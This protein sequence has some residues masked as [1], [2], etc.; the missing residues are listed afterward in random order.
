[1]APSIH[2][3]PLKTLGRIFDGTLNDRK[4]R[5]ELEVKVK[6]GLRL[7]DRSLFTG[8]MKLWIL[9][10]VLVPKISWHLM[11]YEIPVSWVER[12]EVKISKH[13]RKWLGVGKMLNRSAL[14]CKEVP[15]PLPVKSLVSIFKT[16]KTNALMQ[17]KQSSDK[18]VAENIP[19][20]KTGRKWKVADAVERAESR[21]KLDEVAGV[22]QTNRAGFGLL[23]RRN[24]PA[25][26]SK[27]YRKMVIN[28]VNKEEDEKMFIESVQQG[29][30]GRW[31]RWQEYV[32]RDLRWK[33]LLGS[34]PRLVAFGLGATYYSLAT[35]E[36]L[37]R[38]G[39]VLEAKC[40]L[41]GA[42]RCAVWLSK[43]IGRRAI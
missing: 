3:K 32:H 41:C 16:T 2:K 39:L 14:Y 28:M 33:S 34:P 19:E 37:L 18:L 10:H 1:M 8:V 22:G 11:I 36:N 40:V 13:I 7:I 17:L 30:Q 12:L 31:T 29:V 6:E 5:E 42:D 20:L 27:E 43:S 35:P 4:A 24:T 15:C 21:L 9:H 26:N 38:W 25:K 23:P